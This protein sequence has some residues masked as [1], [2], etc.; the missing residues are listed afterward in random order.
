MLNTSFGTGGFATFSIDGPSTDKAAGVAITHQADGKIVV[1]GTA[2][3]PTAQSTFAVARQNADGSP[4]TTFGKGGTVFTNFAPGTIVAANDVAIQPDGK[5]LVAGLIEGFINNNF[6]EDFAVARYDT[7]GSLDATFGTGGEVVADFG[8][9]SSSEASSIVVTPAGK[10]LVAGTTSA[11][12]GD[13]AMAQ[14][15][16]DGSLDTTFGTGGKVVSS[17]GPNVFA[18]DVGAKVG[19]AVLPSGQI[20]LAGLVINE[21]NGFALDFGLASYNADGSL[22]TSFGTGGEV[23]TEFADS[24][25]SSVAGIAVE[26]GSGTVV[27][28]G[29]LHATTGFQSSFAL[30]RYHVSDGSL[31][32]SFGTGGEV[33]TPTAPGTSSTAT[34]I[35]IQP[36]DGAIIVSGTL[37]GSDS[38]FN[39]T[40]DLTLAR[41]KAADGS[42]DATFGTGGEV[43]TD[44]GT[45]TLTSGSGVTV[46]ADG[47]IV[48]AATVGGSVIG[49]FGLAR[50]NRSGSLDAKFNNGG[51]VVIN[52]TMPAGMSTAGE[53]IQAD[54]KIVVAG[55]AGV[56]VNGAVASRIVLTRFNRDGSLDTTFGTNGSVITHF[57]T[58]GEPGGRGDDRAG[59]RDP[60]R[61]DRLGLRQRPVRGGFRPGSP[62]P[63]RRPGH[64]IR[65]RRRCPRRLR[66]RHGGHGLGRG[67]RERRHDRRGRVRL[68]I[69]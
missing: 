27:V 23:L 47:K 36:A 13:F 18:A 29:S 60:R 61:G 56:V 43:V 63:E 68:G 19:A 37:D 8:P 57:S 58:T 67:D 35:A 7:N 38:N 15:N 53:A 33:I 65:P 45:G 2:S 9:N 24:Q 44:F 59:R 12:G 25:V 34:G 39:A 6:A 5:I 66:V 14:L 30:A 49:G 55:S 32:A 1:A 20:V 51:E 4:D 48:A 17:F 21:N 64:P 40:K 3:G 54:G 11:D 31:D 16:A 10:I 50:Y 62:Q 42:L 52:V 46:Q 26:P 41:Y 69:R 22:K 28:A